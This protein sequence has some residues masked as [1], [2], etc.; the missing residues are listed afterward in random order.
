MNWMLLPVGFLAG[1]CASM[2][3]GGGFVLM[4]YLTLLAGLKEL[5]GKKD[6]SG[7]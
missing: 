5:F 3:I 7:G 4:L 1:V 6:G 2:G